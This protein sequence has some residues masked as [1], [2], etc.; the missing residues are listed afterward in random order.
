[1]DRHLRAECISA[2]FRRE[3]LQRRDCAFRMTEKKASHPFPGGGFEKERVCSVPLPAPSDR[4]LVAGPE[5]D[6]PLPGD[7]EVSG[8]DV[9]GSVRTC[10]N[11]NTNGRNNCE[12]RL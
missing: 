12:I 6:T 2:E 1:M 11:L 3:A 9:N 10:R 7:V 4:Q 5:T 8:G